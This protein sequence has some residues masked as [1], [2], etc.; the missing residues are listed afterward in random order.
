MTEF[1]GPFVAPRTPIEELLG[2]IWAQVLGVDRV[3]LHDNFF[4]LG[5][6]SLRGARLISRV[7]DAFNVELSL[8]NLFEAPTVAALARVIEQQQIEQAAEEDIAEWMEE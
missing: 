6:H 5:G 3:S 4:K 2:T 1:E 7:R 8:Q